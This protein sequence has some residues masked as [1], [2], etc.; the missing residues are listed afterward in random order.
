LD[1]GRRVTFDPERYSAAA[2]GYAV[3]IHKSRGATVDRVYT[4]ADP[5]MDRNATYVALTRHRE[6]V[7]L[8]ADRW[9]REAKF[10]SIAAPGT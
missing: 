8:Y 7:H 9:R 2:H 1:D 3:T 6:A 5:Y 4:L 10:Q